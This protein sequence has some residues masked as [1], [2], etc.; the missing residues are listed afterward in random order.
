M[1]LKFDV[2]P[3]VLQVMFK[4]CQCLTLQQCPNHH[5]FASRF[6]DGHQ[7]LNLTEGHQPLD[8]LLKA[9]ILEDSKVSGVL[10]S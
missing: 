6:F 8:P 10:G 2:I 4:V 5:A 7:V 1:R 3:Y 9:I